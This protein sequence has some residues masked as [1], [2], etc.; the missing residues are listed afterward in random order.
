MEF[1]I[2]SASKDGRYHRHNP[3]TGKWTSWVDSVKEA[4]TRELYVNA[5]SYM[6][7]MVYIQEKYKYEQAIVGVNI[8]K[9]Y[10]TLEEFKNLYP[11]YFI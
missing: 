9:T 3:I 7:V 6:S 11:E 4:T 5:P 2:E 1:V 8:Q 10:H